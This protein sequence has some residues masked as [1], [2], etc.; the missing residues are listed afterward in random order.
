MA[1]KSP[2]LIS[3]GRNIITNSISISP[4]LSNWRK[5]RR[6]PTKGWA[7]IYSR[8]RPA[9]KSGRGTSISWCRWG[10]W[11][12]NPPRSTST[13]ICFFYRSVY[14]RLG[15]H[16]AMHKL[17]QRTEFPWPYSRNKRNDKEIGWN[18]C[19]IDRTNNLQG[20]GLHHNKCDQRVGGVQLQVVISFL[21]K[22]TFH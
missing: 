11:S 16:T 4:K 12:Q 13:V 3:S 20:R 5:R 9:N 14:F 6:F 19:E 15:W 1:S 21:F 22:G 18:G 17:P 2:L 7:S 10:S 8:P